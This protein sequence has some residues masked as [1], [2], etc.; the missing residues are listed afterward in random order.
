MKK[1]LFFLLLLGVIDFTSAKAQYGGVIIGGGYYRGP[2]YYRRPYP[3]R[4]RPQPRYQ[5]REKIPSFQ[6]SVNINLG[7]GYPNLDKDQLADFDNFYKG[8]SITQQGP[9]IGS[10]DYQFSRTTSIGVMGT[11][12]K[13][14][15]P[16]YDY[17][18]SSMTPAFTGS[19]ENW[20]IMLNLVNYFPIY[21]KGAAPY[22]KTAIGLNNWTQQNYLDAQGN[23]AAI[24]QMP[25]Q[26]AY[27]V[28][29]GSKFMLSP[30]AGLFLEAGYG[31]Y[32]VSGGLTFKF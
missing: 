31:K 7:Y 12:G 21:S 14:S 25:S 6:P 22:I 10:I 2:G 19:L 8:S 30:R 32:I 29:L 28:A 3:P 5:Q 4:R 15:V 1:Y 18:S 23:K 17:N 26:L 16:Y 13:V 9:F 27:Q 24:A 20:S 11:Y